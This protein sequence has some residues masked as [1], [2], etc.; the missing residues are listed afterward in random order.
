MHNLIS[1]GIAFILGAG[2]GWILNGKHWDVFLTSYVPA[3]ATLVAAFY[4]AKYAFQFQ[5]AKEKDDEKKR[6]VI[7]GNAAI[8]T[9]IRMICSLRD[10]QKQII[11]PA[12]NVP[13]RFIQMRPALRFIKD[14][15]ELNIESMYFLLE[16]ED[17]TLLSELVM[18]SD[19]YH[20]AI[21]TYNERSRI[22][23]EDV[24]TVLERAGFVQGGTYSSEE[25]KTLLGDRLYIT[26]QQATDATIEQVD[27]ALI[28]LN[29]VANKLH[30]SLKKLYPNDTIIRFEIVDTSTK[31]TVETQSA[32]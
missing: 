19:R 2:A 29:R 32:N 30:T 17:K 14:E 7:N 28:T 20:S 23:R 16:T 10:I 22:H 27:N 24:Q 3:L 8:F 9:L 31:E 4:G 26:I 13:F 21:G 25:I 11:D 15:N 12:R 6:N 18:E 5:R 1:L